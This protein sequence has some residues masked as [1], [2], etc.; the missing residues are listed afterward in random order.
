LTSALGWKSLANT[1]LEYFTIMTL[2]D[3]CS[4]RKEY[5]EHY[6]QY[7]LIRPSAGEVANC[8]RHAN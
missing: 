5:L 6:S 2:A 7:S 3:N 8:F 4:V 1:E